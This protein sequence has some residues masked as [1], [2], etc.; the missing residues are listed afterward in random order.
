MFGRSAKKALSGT[1][2]IEAFGSSFDLT[3][4]E[5]RNVA[6]PPAE[7]PPRIRLVSGFESNL[8]RLSRS[9]KAASKM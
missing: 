4:D 1:A 6:R 8:K 2:T 5:W 3:H 7:V 9:A